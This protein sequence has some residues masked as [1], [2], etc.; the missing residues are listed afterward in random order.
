MAGLEEL[1]EL[2]EAELEGF[3]LHAAF[4]GLFG[5]EAFFVLQV[6]DALFDGLGDG[7]LVDDYVDGLG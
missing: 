2:V 6:E 4:D 3:L 7:E 5:E 1:H